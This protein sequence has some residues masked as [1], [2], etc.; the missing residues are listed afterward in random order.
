MF[1]HSVWITVHM[2]CTCLHMTQ[3][4]KEDKRRK[5]LARCIPDVRGL[6]PGVLLEAGLKPQ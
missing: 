3:G 1:V 4:D 6:L 5:K 2:E